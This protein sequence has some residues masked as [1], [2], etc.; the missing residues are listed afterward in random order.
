M[1][2]MYSLGY[3]DVTCR[4]IYAEMTRGFQAKLRT[5]STFLIPLY[6]RKGFT[7]EQRCLGTFKTALGERS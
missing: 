1:C 7:S 6:C 3:C 4:V 5:K 2:V